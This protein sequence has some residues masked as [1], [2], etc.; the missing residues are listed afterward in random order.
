MTASDR[1]RV[2]QMVELRLLYRQVNAL[3]PRIA[4]LERILGGEG[5]NGKGR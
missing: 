4:E 2:E 3:K 1:N 5:R